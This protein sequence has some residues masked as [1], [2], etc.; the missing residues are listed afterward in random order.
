MEMILTDSSAQNL[1]V[2]APNEAT[3]LIMDFYARVDDASPATNDLQQFFAAQFKDHNRPMTA[4]ADVPD[5]LVALGLFKQLR[6][7]FPDMRHSLDIVAGIGADR[8][9][10]YWTFTG[11]HTGAFFGAPASGRPVKING[12]DIF[13]VEGGAFVEQWHVEELMALFQQIAD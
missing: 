8:A 12:V 6:V 10:V 2:T 3:G 5:R 11:T 1:L 9:M 4:P 7:G 13:Q